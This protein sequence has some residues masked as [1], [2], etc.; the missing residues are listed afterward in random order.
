M[1]NDLLPAGVVVA[2]AF[3]D[4]GGEAAFPGEESYVARAVDSRRREFVTARRCAREALAGLGIAPAPIPRGPRGEPVWPDGVIGSLTHCT[5]YRGA[6]VA[7][8]GE[9]VSLGI[10][11]EP[12]EPLPPGILE[13]VTVPAE[14]PR[15]G[16]LAGFDTQVCWDRLLFSAKESIYKAWFPLTRRMLDFEG[17]DLTVDPVAGTFAATLLV[18]GDRVDGGPPLTGLNGRWMVRN[19]LVLTATTVLI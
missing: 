7:R 10:D 11:A 15:L 18:P 5:G 19:G 14:R 1:I 13:A 6:A 16:T 17:A 2:E 3:G 9:P 4:H 8:R 12:N